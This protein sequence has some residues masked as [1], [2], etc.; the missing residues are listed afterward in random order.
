M[1]D[2]GAHEEGEKL[3][4]EQKDGQHWKSAHG[5]SPGPD[6]DGPSPSVSV[7][8]D[9]HQGQPPAGQEALPEGGGHVA[10]AV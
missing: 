2:Y 1:K 8:A 10:G 4:D 6:T 9:F 3:V 5:V 7:R